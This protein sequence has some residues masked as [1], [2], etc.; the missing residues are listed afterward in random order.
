M[1]PMAQTRV[2]WNAVGNYTMIVIKCSFLC[3]NPIWRII[4]NRWLD[5]W[6]YRSFIV[7]ASDINWHLCLL[8]VMR[9][10]K[11]KCKETI[12][13]TC[14]NTKWI[15]P[16]NACTI[17]YHVTGIVVVVVV[18]SVARSNAATKLEKMTRYENNQF[19]MASIWFIYFVFIV[20]I[21][22]VSKCV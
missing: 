7:V 20:S 22:N 2:F 1:F 12:R 10:E 13:E 19:S 21:V 4:K 9:A 18:V 16:V 15:C 14:C 17:S 3:P 6:F 8:D 5:K 11:C